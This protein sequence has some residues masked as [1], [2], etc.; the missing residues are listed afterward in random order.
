MTPGQVL[1]VSETVERRGSGAPPLVPRGGKVCRGYV[2]RGW[3]NVSPL[4]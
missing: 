1:R 3:S 2:P 4:P